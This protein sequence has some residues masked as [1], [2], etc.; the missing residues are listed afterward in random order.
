MSGDVDQGEDREGGVGQHALEGRAKAARDQQYE[1]AY[2]DHRQDQKSIVEGCGEDKDNGYQHQVAR[3]ARPVRIGDGKCIPTRQSPATKAV[4]T[5]TS[6]KDPRN[7][8]SRTRGMRTA[9]VMTRFMI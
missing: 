9:A 4:A 1:A 7:K 3:D 5:T 6:K 2:S 8:S